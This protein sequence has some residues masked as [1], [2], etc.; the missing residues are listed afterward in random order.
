MVWQRQAAL[1]LLPCVLVSLAAAGALLASDCVTQGSPEGDPPPPSPGGGG[2]G[3]G[4]GESRF[5]R[6]DRIVGCVRAGVTG[7]GAVWG[8][9][10]VRRPG[11]G[12][13]GVRGCR[14]GLS[15]GAGSGFSVRSSCSYTWSPCSIRGVIAERCI[16][17]GVGGMIVREGVQARGCPNCRTS[18]PSLNSLHPQLELA[19][20]CDP[21]TAS[22]SQPL[23]SPMGDALVRANMAVGQAC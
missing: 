20:P 10:G 12:W 18:R 14:G 7:R 1:H 11:L 3:D 8:G 19:L 4:E 5:E 21:C 2:G 23:Q 6:A 15:F 13:P 22:L 17:A 16:R 9:E